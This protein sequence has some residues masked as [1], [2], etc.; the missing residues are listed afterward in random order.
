M[1]KTGWNRDKNVE[2]TRVCAFEKNGVLSGEHVQL[3]TGETEEMNR[4]ALMV[5]KCMPRIPGWWIKICRLGKENTTYTEQERYDFLRGLVKI[6]N[7]R[8]RVTVERYGEKNIPEENGFILFPNHQGMFDMLALIDT[9]PNPL[10]VVIK[11]EAANW[12]LVKQV[13]KLLRAI[14]IDR[15]DIKSSLAV[16]NQMTEEVK[17]GRNY[18]IFAE[19]TRSKEGNQI[20]P[21]KAGTFKSAVNAKCPIVPVA[22]IDSFKP[23]DLPSSKKE[24]VQVHYLRPI[25]YEEYKSMRTPQIAKMVSERIQEEIAKKLQKDENRA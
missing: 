3:E 8:G 4:I 22:L 20:L 25:S 7:K 15:S 19:G 9:C 16:I 14:A 17:Q 23:F 11:K 6:V 24:T 5:L 10:S 18:V 1:W 21:F 12:I 13:L 2:N